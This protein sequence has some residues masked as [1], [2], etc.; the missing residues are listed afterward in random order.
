MTK[1]T[2]NQQQLFDRVAKESKKRSRRMIRRANLDQKQRGQLRDAKQRLGQASLVRHTNLRYRYEGELVLDTILAA[3]RMLNLI[4]IGN[5]PGG[6][7]DQGLRNR[8]LNE[9]KLYSATNE[10]QRIM[11]NMPDSERPIYAV[12][13]YM[14]GT[15]SV[16]SVGFFGHYRFVLRPYLRSRAT[17]T[18]CDS[19]QAELDE[20]YVWRDIEGVLATKLRERFWFE[21]VATGI[22]P[23]AAEGITYIEAQILGGVQL[24]DVVRL[25]YPVADRM[26]K[27]FFAKLQQ[28]ELDHGIEI[29]HY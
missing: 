18:P 2:A 22:D 6:I 1:L 27:F 28:L 24:T 13:D 11:S 9:F 26:D 20:V 15:G 16:S 21:Y 7:R 23:L 5:F 19:M 17:F 8:L 25:Y 10:A 4:E 12:V 29:V 3:K 14:G